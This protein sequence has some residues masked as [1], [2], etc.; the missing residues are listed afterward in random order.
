[1]LCVPNTHSTVVRT[2]QQ[3]AAVGA[4]TQAIYAAIVTVQN[5]MRAKIRQKSRV[6]PHSAAYGCCC[7]PPTQLPRVEAAPERG[8]ILGASRIHFNQTKLLII[9]VGFLNVGYGTQLT[10][11]LSNWLERPVFPD[12]ESMRGEPRGAP[13][14]ICEENTS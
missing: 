3:R 5:G 10:E 14:Y 1:M 8:L 13:F 4:P 2:A 9:A 6:G 11:R 12:F 7:A